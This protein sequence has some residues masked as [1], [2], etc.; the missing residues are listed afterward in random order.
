MGKNSLGGSRGCQ[1]TQ[2]PAAVEVTPPP[3]LKGHE[4]PAVLLKPQ[5]Q[6]VTQ[7][8]T[9]HRVCHHGDTS[10]GAEK[11]PGR[12]L[13]A[14]PLLPHRLPS[15]G[16]TDWMLSEARAQEPSWGCDIEKSRG[17]AV[18]WWYRVGTAAWK[19][20]SAPYPPVCNSSLL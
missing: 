15:S 9:A 5:G 12:M 3:A 14:L 13:G 10:D 1:D 11:F 8:R 4:E 16:S 17:Q 18:G 19:L 20:P 6:L 7:G 2:A